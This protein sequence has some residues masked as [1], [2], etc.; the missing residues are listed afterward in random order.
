[1]AENHK[2]LEMNIKNCMRYKI[3]DHT[4]FFLYIEHC[5]YFANLGN[6]IDYRVTDYSGDGYYKT[7]KQWW[8]KC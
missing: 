7:E 1:M 5:W 6:V 4:L 8:T 3:N 2:Y